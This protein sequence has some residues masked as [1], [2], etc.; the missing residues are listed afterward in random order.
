MPCAADT[1]APMSTAAVRISAD[2]ANAALAAD[3]AGR[4]DGQVVDGPAD[5]T[6]VS[7]P[8]SAEAIHVVITGVLDE[9]LDAWDRD[10]PPQALAGVLW[11]GPGQDAALAAAAWWQLRSQTP[12]TPLSDLTDNNERCLR[13]SVMGVTRVD[14]TAASEVEVDEAQIRAELDALPQIH[15]LGRAIDAV[16]GDSGEV[17]LRSVEGF[18]AALNALDG[19]APMPPLGATP[20]LDSAVAEHL[21]QVQRSGFGRWR[22]AKARAQTQEDLSTATREVA[23]DRLREVIA[24]RR[25]AQLVA[26]KD[27]AAQEAD[28]RT[29]EAV[30]DA[31]HAVT[32]PVTPD[33]SRV[34]RSWSDNAPAPRRYVLV[35][36]AHAE[37]FADLE[38]VTVRVSELMPPDEAWCLIVQSGFS[39][40]ALQDS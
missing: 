40:P 15:D 2:P 18:R 17:V 23:A 37:Q 16:G 12:T 20:A 4:L 3:L 24:A 32:L 27:A 31:V 34:P 29:L 36:Q 22:G 38:G 8:P 10:I 33:F 14:L 13:W 5:L 39:L 25:D 28:A 19:L 6:V 9:G 30:T 7:G 1:L 35:A 21:R 26:L 11:I